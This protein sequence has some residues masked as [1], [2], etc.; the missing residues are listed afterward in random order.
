MCRYTITLLFSLVVSVQLCGFAGAQNTPAD[1]DA[2]LHVAA[3]SGAADFTPSRDG[4]T[5]LDWIV[6]AAYGAGMLSLGAY[7]ARR[8]ESAED[9]FVGGRS[10]NSTAVGIS[11]LATLLSTISY[12]A[13]PGELIKNGPMIGV[14]LIAAPVTYWVVG[15]GLIPFIM[16]RKVTS[17]YEFLEAE[18]GLG[19]RLLAAT[20][21]LLLRLTWM[22]VM[23]HVAAVAVV[24]VLGLSEEQAAWAV[25]IA[26]LICGSV[27]GVYTAMG[28]LRAVVT[29]DVVQFVLL[30][31]GAILTVVLITWN[32]GGFSWWPTQ[33]HPG[34]DKQPVF[35]FDPHV[36]VTAVGT[37]VGSLLYW[38]CTAGS[39]QTA[40]QRF[41]ATGSARAARKAFL[42]N[43]IAD[44]MTTVLLVLVGL[45]VL[46]FYCAQSVTGTVDIVNGDKLFPQFIA[47]QLPVGVAG[48]V[49]AAMFAAVMSSLD[50]GLNSTASVI[51]TDFI[52]RFGKRSH[53]PKEDLWLSRYL[54]L[55]MGLLIVAVA[56]IVQKVPG[57]ILEMSQKTVGLLVGPLFGI[58][59][60]ALF[61]RFG[62]AFGAWY[63]AWYSC[64]T[65]FLIAFWDM[66]TGEPSLSFQWIVPCALVVS[67]VMGVSL[68][69]LTTDRVKPN[70]RL[71]VGLLAASP[72]AVCNLW[73]CWVLIGRLTALLVGH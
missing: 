54:T 50:S 16:R 49:V 26:I 18:L 19:P 34:W 39:D 15:Y 72:V 24:G 53:T 5:L 10:L 48:L 38:I 65:A 13:T 8:H 37:V 9:F 71:L 21:F 52:R 32:L 67:I 70:A 3:E 17:A 46:G 11:L 42:V 63:S 58:Y 40:I 62:T 22:G 60:L 47:T 68:S 35:S 36:R 25:P 61:V 69:W 56:L 33:W 28:G 27:A 30:F 14:G 29:T 64:T 43:I 44:S 55:G 7:Y 73:I 45:A 41:M 2:T 57:N 51:I 23:I 6:I 66:I 59:F 1:G 12:L 31:G 4:L 20:M